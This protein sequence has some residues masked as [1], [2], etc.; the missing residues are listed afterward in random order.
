MN[1]VSV[2]DTSVE[3]PFTKVCVFDGA[4][5]FWAYLHKIE[6]TSGGRNLIWEISDRPDGYNPDFQPSFWMKVDYPNRDNTKQI[7]R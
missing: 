6:I 1:W 4:N 3:I 5:T 2:E 7:E